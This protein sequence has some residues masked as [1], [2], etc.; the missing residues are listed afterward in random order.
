MTERTIHIG[1]VDDVYEHCERMKKLVQSCFAHSVITCYACGR[2][3]LED[4]RYFDIV[5]LDIHLK[6]ED[7]IALCQKLYEKSD[8][9]VYVTD[10]LHRVTDAFGYRVVGFLSKAESDENLIEK[11]KKIEQEYFGGKLTLECTNGT[12]EVRSHD[13]MFIHVRNRTL[14]VHIQGNRVLTVR[15][16]ALKQMYSLL[17]PM[18]FVIVDKGT[19]VN[20]NHVRAIEKDHLVMREGDEIIV[21]RRMRK[22]VEQAWIRK[23]LG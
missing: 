8:L 23:F 18:C 3:I 17:D 1:I 12:V 13:I 10:Q 5:F 2:Q 21:S 14:E 22:P 20:L 4:N 15:N 11:L 19:V 9:F 16:M 7:G 6:Q